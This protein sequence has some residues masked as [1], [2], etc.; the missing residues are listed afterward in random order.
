MNTDLRKKL[1]TE[2]NSLFTNGLHY[3]F[4]EDGTKPPYA[5]FFLVTGP[6]ANSD[7]KVQSEDNF[8]QFSVFASS[9]GSAETLTKN[10]RDK[11]KDINFSSLATV[12]V[13]DFRYQFSRD[14]P[15]DDEEKIYQIVTQ[16][17]ASLTQ[18]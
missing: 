4:A 16:F 1:Y 8:I 11:I 13:H 15:Y 3:Y 14:M 18:I 5:V 2:C 12:V 6:D 17:K 7:N 9:Q 10:L